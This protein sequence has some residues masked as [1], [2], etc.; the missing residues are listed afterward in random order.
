MADTRA[1][2]SSNGKLTFLAD[3]ELSRFRVVTEGSDA[4]HIK[5]PD[6]TTDEPTGVTTDGAD[7]AEQEAAV[8]LLGKG[9]T[10][11]VKGNGTGS[12][13]DWLT[14]EDPSTDAGGKVRAV[15][16]TA[17]AYWIIGKALEDFAD[18]QE[19]A[20]KDCEPFIAG[21]QNANGQLGLPT[22]ASDPTSPVVGQSYINSA[23]NSVRD[24][25]NGTWRIR[26]F[27]SMI[28]SLFAVAFLALQPVVKAASYAGA[29]IKSSTTGQVGS[30]TA[31]DTVT[32]AGDINVGNGNLTIDASSGNITAAGDVSA[33]GTLTV[34]GASTF[35]GGIA[36]TG[37][38]TTCDINGG[39]IDAAAIGGS[40]PAAGAFTSLSASG[41]TTLTGN[42]DF[43]GIRIGK[44]SEAIAVGDFTD[45]AGTSGYLDLSTQVPAGSMV[46]GFTFVGTGAFAGDT[47]AV[48]EVGISGDTDAF[49]MKTDG[50]VFTAATI[51]SGANQDANFCAAATTVR[52]TVTGGSDFTAVKANGNGAGTVTVWYVM[53]SP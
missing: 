14:P 39:T 4:D 47:T 26:S 49:S 44:V 35:S 7:A 43:T 28:V 42:L 27:V 29:V 16:S 36:N 11:I 10:K 6:A 21:P 18:E 1:R 31:S 22:F 8:E 38:I 50:S 24:Y 34:T 30:A 41:N 2:K 37:T 53:P 33:G 48:M 51:G 23:D 3:E 52:V 9:E 19:F 25:V 13:G 12:K 32:Q 20:M 45:G 5:Y 15:P 46:L 40:T 17:G